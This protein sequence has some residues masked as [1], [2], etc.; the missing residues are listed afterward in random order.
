MLD[1]QVLLEA[2][3]DNRGT[4]TDFVYRELN[5]ATCDYLGLARE[6]LLGHGL[7]ELTPGVAG[8]GLFAQYLQC[9]DTGEPVIMDDF[10]YDNEI[11]ADTRRYDL[12]ATRV[13]AT[14]I[15]LTWRDVTDRFRVTRLLAEAREM[16]RK[17]DTRWRRLVDNSGIGMAT[18]TPDGIFQT[19][20]PALCAFFGYDAETLRT[21]TWQDLTAPDY[22][23]VD[24]KY[25][26]EVLAG[27]S[28][29][30]RM[31]KQFVHADGHLIWG[32]LS[33]SCLR[34]SG[35]EVESFIA[36]VIDVTT[37]VHALQRLAAQDE[38]NRV[39]VERLEEQGERLTTELRSAVAYVSSIL[40]GDLDGQVR[41]SSR[42][43]P[44]QEL[45]GDSFDYRWIDEDHLIVYL[46]DVSGH[47]I[48]AALLSVS[49][50]NLLRSHSLSLRTLLSPD[51]VLSDLNRRFQMEQQDGKYLT[52]WFGVY[53][54]STRTLRYASAGAPP[55][56]AFA[57]ETPGVA[58]ELSTGGRPLGMFSDSTYS[59]RRFAVPP[60]CRMLLFSDG[61]YE[62]DLD[63]DGQLSL[64]GFKDMVA[65][66]PEPSLDHL[67]DALRD[68]TPSGVFDDD[69]SLV[70]V[71]FD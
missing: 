6:D 10:T 67:L 14:L 20:N 19:V 47:G 49:V 13:T 24:V 57:A 55:A 12:R 7:L 29:S 18:C 16:Q 40:P 1:P 41:V 34:T 59:S 17:S 64:A 71:H 58:V 44:S 65:R 26:E 62:F 23:E 11:L 46:I 53:E 48:G 28:E 51:K 9:L 39:L 56:F 21:K 68:M 4:I 3:T 35:G 45:A 8:S 52:M 66:L 31:T 43:L 27:R 61:V 22:L 2:V 25:A 63:R 50:H 42:Y 33:V 15:N 60:G 30:Y 37:E 54:L 38:R 5:Q 70:Q 69:C 36:Q 32:D